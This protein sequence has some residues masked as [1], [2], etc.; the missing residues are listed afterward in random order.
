MNKMQ[1]D[2]VD[3]RTITVETKD[4]AHGYEGPITHAIIRDEEGPGIQ[5]DQDQARL[6]ARFIL[7]F[8]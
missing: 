4:V 5:L 3:G 2:T 8:V 7:L 6:L 1:T